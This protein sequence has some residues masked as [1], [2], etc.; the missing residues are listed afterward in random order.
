MDGATFWVASDSA[1]YLEWARAQ[2]QGG[3]FAAG[4]VRVAPPPSTKYGRKWRDQ[5][6]KEFYRLEMTKVR[7]PELP[8]IKEPV[9]QYHWVPDFRAER[10]RPAEE[11]SPCTVVLKEL[12]YDQARAKGMLRTVAVEEGIKQAFW[13]E[14][15]LEDDPQRPHPWRI[16]LAP[17]CGVIPTLSV[18][19]ALDLAERAALATLKD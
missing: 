16:R 11:T 9:L 17:G 19:Q 18:Q 8:E 12:I 7:H 14:I 4:P 3:A 2:S 13:I 10:F 1:P 5:G 15:S 6:Q